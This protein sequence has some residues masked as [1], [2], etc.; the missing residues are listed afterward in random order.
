[1]KIDTQNGWFKGLGDLVCFAWIGE[2][3]LQSGGAVEFFAHGWR[4]DVL[5]MFQQRVTDDAK[6]A[7]CPLD[8]YESAIREKSPLNYL[9][10]IAS[11]CGSMV[12]ADSF[13]I[14]FSRPRLDLPPMDREMGRKASSQILVFPEGCWP[15]RVWPRNYYLELCCMLS[16]AGYRVVVV[17]E[18]QTPDFGQFRTIHS[19][20]LPFIA[21]AM[22]SAEL[23]IGN[24]S[25]PAHLAGTIGTPTIAIHGPTTERIFAHLAEVTSFRKQALNCAGCHCLPPFRDSCA[26]G[27][28]EL[29]R[30]FPED[31]AK[32]A[33][34]MLAKNERKKAA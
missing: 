29:Y 19:Q 15:T 28:H 1:M 26:L 13:P 14:D 20:S 31:V 4:A 23:V 3:I 5:R 17:T 27:C 6:G 32:A 18:K 16:D 21:A 11:Q 10:W 8:G 30:T 12:D 22:Q 7:V 24:D 25:G 9:E 33:L 34:R 2:T